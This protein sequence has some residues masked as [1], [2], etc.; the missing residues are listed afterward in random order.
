MDKERYRPAIF[1]VVYARVKDKIEFLVLKRHLHWD[2]WEFPKGGVDRGEGKIISAFREIKEETGLNVV[3]KVQKFNVSG[4]YKYDKQYPERRGF[5]GQTFS[6][7][8]AEVKK[9]FLRGIRVDK[10]EHSDYKWLE[11]P[12]ALK[13]LTWSNQRRCLSVVEEWLKEKE[14]DTQ[15]AQEPDKSGKKK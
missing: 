4:K 15:R 8:A 11:F 5:V 14:R 12:D 7:F 3:G 1:I 6:L 13:K 10:K 9:P 2:G